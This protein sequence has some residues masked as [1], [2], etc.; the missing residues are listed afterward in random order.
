MH[1]VLEHCQEWELPAE[2]ELLLGKV[3]VGALDHLDLL[4]VEVVVDLLKC[5]QNVLW[6]VHNRL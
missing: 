1:L 2:P 5:V 3:G 4:L 6:S